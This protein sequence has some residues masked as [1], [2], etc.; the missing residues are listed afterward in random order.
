MID[1]S[2][3]RCEQKCIQSPMDEIMQVV[4]DNYQAELR[5][6]GEGIRQ[7]ICQELR[8]F[9]EQLPR[10]PGRGSIEVKS[11]SDTSKDFSTV[12]TPLQPSSS[13][14]SA[15]RE[16]FASFDDDF[17][18]ACCDVALVGSF[19]PGSGGMDGSG[20]HC[21][22]PAAGVGMA[23][24][25]SPTG[26]PAGR[27]L[28]GTPTGCPAPL[29]QTS[30]GIPSLECLRLPSSLGRAFT[31]S[32]GSAPRRSRSATVPVLKSST[33]P[34]LKSDGFDSEESGGSE[35]PPER[36]EA[37]GPKRSDSLLA[38]T[39][40][41]SDLFK[42]NF[43][44][45]NSR[46]SRQQS[47]GNPRFR[48]GMTRVAES[49]DHNIKLEN[50]GIWRD[51]FSDLVASPKFNSFI[52]LVIVVNAC[53]IGAQAEH[54]VKHL[55]ENQEPVSLRVLDTL[56]CTV[57]VAELAVRVYVFRSSFFIG[58]NWKFNIFDM[59]LVVMQLVEEALKVMNTG[60]AFGW[61]SILRVLRVA[62]VLRLVRVVHL[63]RELRTMIGSIG[64]SIKS[65]FWTVLLL[66]LM[67]YVV[68][69]CITQIVTFYAEVR[70]DMLAE[71]SDLGAHFSSIF[72]AIFALFG[73]ITGGV[74]WQ[75]VAQPLLDEIGWPIALLFSLYI[76][77]AVFAMLN[78]V[79]GIFVESAL[80]GA[81]AEKDENLAQDVRGAFKIEEGIDTVF[82]REDL[83]QQLAE[84]TCLDKLREMNMSAHE[85]H[86]LFSLIDVDEQNA[87]DAED[88]VDGCLRLN[89]PPKAI[90]V[91]T[92]MYTLQRQTRMWETLI[93]THLM[94]VSSMNSMGIVDTSSRNSMGTVDTSD[95]ISKAR[96][97]QEIVHPNSSNSRHFRIPMDPTDSGDDMETFAQPGVVW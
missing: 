62:K 11:V 45:K 12:A 47:R 35:L 57:F 2:A 1:V 81:K 24:L 66:F 21:A 49:G 58:R 36:G 89:G 77:F 22:P 23:W 93:P 43:S 37:V 96:I 29:H 97:K 46:Y 75:S 56:F 13:L 17:D 65:L 51:T 16:R 94:G 41:S 4:H 3:S 87:I 79:T 86:E 60:E 32:D 44:Q 59:L 39:Q 6:L 61:V 83:E 90:D 14:R 78:V 28:P 10:P 67:I 25:G 5:E 82:R 71:G 52:G 84:N 33:V 54:A 27:A 95:T 9:L 70:P 18:K 7:D 92:L 20:E 74:D 50:V 76:C 42:K 15:A 63:F 80:Q 8:S 34:V 85:M 48:T 69:V 53:A 88:F 30:E 19:G 38:S 91:A 26:C 40:K 31:H 55:H 68:A 73:S 64:N 72:L